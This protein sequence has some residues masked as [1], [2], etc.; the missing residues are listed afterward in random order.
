MT[1]TGPGR[2]ATPSTPM[3][4][5]AA[6]SRASPAI[7]CGR[8][9]S[10]TTARGRSATNTG[11]APK[12]RSIAAATSAA[13]PIPGRRRRSAGRARRPSGSTPPPASMPAG[14]AA[15]R[16]ACAAF[17]STG[18]E[19]WAFAGTGLYYGD[20]L[21]ADSHVFGY[22]VDG[23]DYDHPQRPARAD[24]RQRRAGWPADPGA[25]HGVAGRGETP[26]DP[27]EDRSSTTRT[28][29]STP[30]RSTASA[31]RRE[32]GEGQARQRHD[33]QFPARQG[34]GVPRRQ[35]RMGGRPAAPRRRWSR[36]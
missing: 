10:R 2:C 3:S 26:T 15:R 22:E 30:R 1:N 35:L 24:G 29:A 23:L 25:R 11:P 5:A 13:P 36:W 7:S 16:A 20:L 8:R 4:S 17:P 18:P 6:V 19:H 14:A 12:T 27:A 28:A 34:R 21:G 33:R 32:S 31:E 9:G